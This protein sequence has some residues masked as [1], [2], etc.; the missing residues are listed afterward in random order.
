MTSRGIVIQN[1][2]SGQ[3]ELEEDDADTQS[4]SSDDF[5]VTEEDNHPRS[6]TDKDVLGYM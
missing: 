2:E 3:S 1:L 6:G 4:N 5:L